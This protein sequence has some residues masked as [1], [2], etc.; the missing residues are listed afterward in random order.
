MET[1][2]T[3]LIIDSFYTVSG[4]VL[5][6]LQCLSGKPSIDSILSDENGEKWR[7]V[8]NAVDV[9]GEQNRKILREKE[10]DMMFLFE[11]EPI[12]HKSK[13]AKGTEL[14]IS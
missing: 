8:N 14:Y 10:K 4:V 13:P 9:N 1:A 5:T 12:G 2:K 3:F 7:I 11:L 6:L